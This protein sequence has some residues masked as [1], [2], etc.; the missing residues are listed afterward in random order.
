[1]N[2][3]PRAGPE[4][5]IG[6]AEAVLSRPLVLEPGG[7]W[8]LYLLHPIALC[9]REHPGDDAILH[10]AVILTMSRHRRTHTR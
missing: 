3:G 2:L 6:K 8:Q 4:D 7:T 1:M 10:T 5:Y 9:G